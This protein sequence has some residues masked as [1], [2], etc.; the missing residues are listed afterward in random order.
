[1]SYAKGAMLQYIKKHKPDLSLEEY[2]EGS[3]EGDTVHWEIEDRPVKCAETPE[4]KREAVLAALSR[5][6]PRRRIVIMAAFQIEDAQ[7]K[8]TTKED[9]GISDKLWYEARAMGLKK[10]RD[11]TSFEGL[12]VQDEKPNLREECRKLLRQDPTLKPRHLMQLT[13]CSKTNAHKV[14]AELKRKENVGSKGQVAL[15]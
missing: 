3:I 9:I 6:S 13:G 4:H 11:I 15:R 14:R 8:V 5:I 12:R 7:G 2:L 1:M 10:L